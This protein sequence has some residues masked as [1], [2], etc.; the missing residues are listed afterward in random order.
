M[1]L[2]GRYPLYS[3]GLNQFLLRHDIISV[4]F[5]IPSVLTHVNPVGC[6]S[7]FVVFCKMPARGHLT[8]ILGPFGPRCNYRKII[9]IKAVGKESDRYEA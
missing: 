7:F 5:L 9:T 8:L 1:P 2:P 4:R 6:R 3:Q